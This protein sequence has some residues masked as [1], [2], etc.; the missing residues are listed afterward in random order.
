MLNESEPEPE[1][2]DRDRRSNSFQFFSEKTNLIKFH[3]FDSRR[4]VADRR[5][6]IVE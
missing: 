3:Y 5:R 2:L 1:W 4:T 6:K